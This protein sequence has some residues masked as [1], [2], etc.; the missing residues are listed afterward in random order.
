[1]EMLPYGE[2][3]PR[4]QKE[5]IQHF[6]NFSVSNPLQSWENPS[7]SAPPPEIGGSE[8]VGWGP[9]MLMSMPWV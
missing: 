8:G 5:L 4:P 6:S 1:M 7:V 2:E 9:V 3:S